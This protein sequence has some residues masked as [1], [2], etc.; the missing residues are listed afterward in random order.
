MSSDVYIDIENK[1]TIRIGYLALF[2]FFCPNDTIHS[3]EEL[4]E[5][6][7][8][9]SLEIIE[10]IV[11]RIQLV[12]AD[13]KWINRL[14]QKRFHKLFGGSKQLPYFD[15]IEPLDLYN[16]LKRHKLKK[17]YLRID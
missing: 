13:L 1:V 7:P 6:I 3:L 15:I 10:A 12:R 8:L 17:W 16:Q 14:S 4:Q 5:K 11:A 9:L 2:Q